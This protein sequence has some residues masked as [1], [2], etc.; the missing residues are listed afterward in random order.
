M[1]D[2][3]DNRFMRLAIEQAQIG[4]A[5]GNAAIGCVIVCD[6]EVLA[7]GHNQVVSDR[8][9]TAHAE[10]VTIRKASHLVPQFN[11]IGMTLYSTLQPCGM[12]TMA[13]L[14]A[15]ISR[16]VY[17]AGKADVHP[18]YFE[19]RHL[20][21]RDYIQDAYRDKIA[22]TGEILAGECAALYCRPSDTGSLTSA[23]PL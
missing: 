22:L 18:M 23:A 1:A 21:T 5:G 4:R 16:I 14:W 11:L 13:S 19:E 9:P 17:G 12:C 7:A 6:G 8:D 10:I 15:N 20:S 3:T 2:D